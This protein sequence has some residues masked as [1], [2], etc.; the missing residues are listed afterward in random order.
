MPAAAV[1]GPVEGI[2]AGTRRRLAGFARTLRDNGFK[3]GLTE[4]RD[5]L[6]VARIAGRHAAILAQAGV[7]L[8]VR[9]NAFRL[10]AVRRDFRRLLE[11]PRHAPDAD[12]ERPAG[13]RQNR[14]ASA[15]AGSC[16]IAAV[17][18]PTTSSGAPA[19]TVTTTPIRADGAKAPRARK[20]SLRRTSAIS[21]I[22]TRSPRCTRWRRAW[23]RRCGRGSFAASRPADVGAGSTSAAPSIAAC[24]RA[25]RRS[26]WSGAA[27]RRSRCGSSSCSMPPAR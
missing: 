13:K 5:A 9:R 23:R 4:T 21:S 12:A 26:I 19:P 6:A 1:K 15:G 27:A 8:A 3:V 7:A 20:V 17:V 10:G 16:A 2:G 25:E 24:H 14:V 22:P 18:C 11:R